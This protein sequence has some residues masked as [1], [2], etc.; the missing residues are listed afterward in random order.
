[1]AAGTIRRHREYADCS[2]NYVMKEAIMDVR[3]KVI[4]TLS[5]V[6]QKDF[7][8][9][10]DISRESESKWDSLKHV[11]IIFAL[12]DSFGVSFSEDD[13]T[14]MTSVADIVA[15]LALHDAS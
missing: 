2:P 3:Q 13:M 14:R 6:L 1:M 5:L 4:E 11:E 9:D 15:C 7:A 8:E 10:Q 12:E